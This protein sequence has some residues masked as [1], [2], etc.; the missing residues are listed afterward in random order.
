M[1]KMRMLFVSCLFLLVS[2]WVFV[3]CGQREEPV[4]PPAAVEEASEETGQKGE[5][6]AE[7]VKREAEEAL[8]TAT[9]YT[10]QQRQAYQ[11]KMEAKLEEFGRRIDE[12]KAEAEAKKPEVEAR[13]QEEIKQL[14]Q[15]R[16]AAREKLDE[17]RS[18]SEKAWKDLKSE[19]DVIMDDV[20]EFIKK[21]MP[22]ED[23]AAPGER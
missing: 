5:V 18:A 16:E 12:L 2:V 11:A 1:A 3:S 13:L 9:T 4:E 6:T 8:E 19:L 17:L 20:E 21:R 15:K 23:S 10:A 14:E 7:D 22:S